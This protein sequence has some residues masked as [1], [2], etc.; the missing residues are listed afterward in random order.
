MCKI[1][2]TTRTLRAA[3]EIGKQ[4]MEIYHCDVNINFIEPD[5]TQK[6][7]AFYS[8]NLVEKKKENKEPEVKVNCF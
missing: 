2:Y 8:I 6:F 1:N 3:N 4:L 5:N 7:V